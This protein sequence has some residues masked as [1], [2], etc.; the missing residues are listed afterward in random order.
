MTTLRAELERVGEVL[1]A[2]RKHERNEDGCSE[3]PDAPHGFDRNQSHSEDMYVC[4]CTY[5]QPDPAENQSI[6]QQATH[7]LEQ[8]HAALVAAVEDGET[9]LLRQTEAERDQAELRAEAYKAD[10]ERYRFLRN[11]PPRSLAVY[12]SGAYWDGLGLDAAIDR[13]RGVTND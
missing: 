2:Y 1:A 4:E 10:A 11:N 7:W 9:G 6:A 12:L 5:W 3:H 13:A 8:H